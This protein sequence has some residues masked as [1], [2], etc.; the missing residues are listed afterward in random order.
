M[1]AAMQAKTAEELVGE[2]TPPPKM[3]TDWPAGAP[4][5]FTVKPWLRLASSVLEVS[6]RIGTKAVC[7]SLRSFLQTPLP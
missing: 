5:Q 1:T 2:S 6:I 4:V 7:M 3:M